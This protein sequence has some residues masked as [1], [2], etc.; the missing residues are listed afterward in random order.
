MK[1]KLSYFLAASL[2]DLK[3]RKNADRSR[4]PCLQSNQDLGT[5]IKKAKLQFFNTTVDI[6]T[7]LC[8][9]SFNHTRDFMK[10]SRVPK[11]NV[12][13]TETLGVFSFDKT[14]PNSYLPIVS[15]QHIIYNFP[16]FW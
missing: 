9:Q 6:K 5:V 11:Q 2:G 7:K 16:L 8:V 4:T 15:T 1:K 13:G 10:L 3:G 14:A 12:V